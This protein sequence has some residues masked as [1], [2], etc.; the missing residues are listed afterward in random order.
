MTPA[1]S[2]APSPSSTSSISSDEVFDLGRINPPSLRDVADAKTLDKVFDALA[3]D[4]RRGILAVLHDHGGSLS[5]HDIAR[6]FSVKWQG[7]SRHLR[8]LT[9]AGLV[10]CEV[11]KNE[12]AYTLNNDQLRRVAGRWV[13]RVATEGRPDKDGRP[14]FEFDE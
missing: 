3:S 4:I 11:R 6:R 10:D 9:T 7:I 8:V 1:R 13:M 2:S 12:R 14:V 5:S